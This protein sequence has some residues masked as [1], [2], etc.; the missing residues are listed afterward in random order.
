MR[1]NQKLF[2][3]LSSFFMDLRLASSNSQYARER[4]WKRKWEER[5][6]E[7]DN[8]EKWQTK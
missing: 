1:Y 2:M 4:K 8:T 5:E 6:K 3:E 7:E